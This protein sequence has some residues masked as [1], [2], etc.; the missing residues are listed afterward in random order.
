MVALPEV[1]TEVGQA[2]RH[3]VGVYSGLLVELLRTAIRAVSI[4]PSAPI[5]RTQAYDFRITGK[6]P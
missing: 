5:L 1:E 2:E 6:A 4:R 3:V